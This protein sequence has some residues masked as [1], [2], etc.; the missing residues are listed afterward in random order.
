VESN[1]RGPELLPSYELLRERLSREAKVL[2]IVL[3]HSWG[4]AEQVAA[5]DAQ[6]LASAGVNVRVVCL[7]GCPLHQ[8]LKPD[9][10]RLEVHAVEKGSG[11][12][13]LIRLR[14]VLFSH[15]L[16]G[17]NLIHIHQPFLLNWLGPLLWNQK[18]VG[19]VLTRHAQEQ[20]EGEGVLFK[21]LSRRLDFVM[22]TTQAG[23][24]QVLNE[25][26][27]P[28]ARVG[29]VTL[30][31][32]FER[33]DPDKV[34]PQKQR[35]AWG[36]SDS[37]IVVGMV[38]RIDPNKGQATLIRAAAGLHRGED[39]AQPDLKFVIVGEESLGRVS[40]YLEE[41]NEMVGQFRL[42]GKVHFAGYMEELPTVMSAFDLFVMPSR[43][44]TFGLV[45]LEAMAMECPIVLSQGENAAEIVGRQE[46]GLLIRADDAFD[47]QLALRKL[48]GD[49]ELRRRMG[50]RARA[51]VKR[52]YDRRVRLLRTL[53]IYDRVLQR[54][55]LLARNDL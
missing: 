25:V 12:S 11:I 46:F 40:S 50:K 16:D 32:D 31:L 22:V 39:E 37:T 28:E 30:G 7:D 35:E 15:L 36:A 1:T 13:W 20:K 8:I 29:V 45:A 51:H 55:R 26:A 33:F 19:L 42:E 24:R 53:D 47:L 3:S 2:Q 34:D 27:L 41:L 21:F 4:P 23:K 48:L 43:R 44:E 52:H 17:F 38:G 14:R 10:N 18:G 49:P 6:D 9:G 54:R 5:N